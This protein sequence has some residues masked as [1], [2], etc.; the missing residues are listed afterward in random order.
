MLDTT[1]R[2]PG[3]RR[4]AGARGH[5]RY[6]AAYHRADRRL[7]TLRLSAARNQGDWWRRLADDREFVGAK[8]LVLAA[9]L[10]ITALLE[11]VI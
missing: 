7:G 1:H 6:A 4:S 8:L 5:L 2:R 11:R 3:N 9:L 10:V